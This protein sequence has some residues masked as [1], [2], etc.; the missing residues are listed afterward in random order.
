LG[1]RGRGISKLKA[2][3]IYRVRSR[4]ASLLRETLSQNK[5]NNN[6]ENNNKNCIQYHKLRVNIPKWK[7]WDIEWKIEPNQYKKKSQRANTKSFS[8]MLGIWILC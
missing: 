3:I 4:T 2:S 1:D 5:N 8:Y 6:N 7:N